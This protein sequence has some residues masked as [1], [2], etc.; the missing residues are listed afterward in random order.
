[1]SLDVFGYQALKQ[2]WQDAGRLDLMNTCGTRIPAGVFDV[3]TTVK[4]DTHQLQQP[5]S[6]LL[7]ALLCKRAASTNQVSLMYNA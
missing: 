2:D 1:M 5:L 6:S 3:P 7:T 4:G